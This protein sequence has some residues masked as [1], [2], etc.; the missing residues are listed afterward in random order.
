MQE[1]QGIGVVLNLFHHGHASL[2]ES[3]LQELVRSGH[4]LLREGYLGQIIF[5]VVG[6]VGQRVLAALFLLVDGCVLKGRQRIG[7]LVVVVFVKLIAIDHRLI[8]ALPVV[9]VLALA[10]SALEFLFTRHDGLGVVEVPGS[11]VLRRS[12]RL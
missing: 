9:L 2:V 4:L 8:T 7:R 6:V 12:S 10:P 3:F 1:A 5:A 11:L